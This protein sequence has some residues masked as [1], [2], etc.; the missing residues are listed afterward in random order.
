MRTPI[1]VV[2][3]LFSY[4][5]DTGTKYVLVPSHLIAILYKDSGSTG[6]FRVPSTKSRIRCEYRDRMR[7][8]D[9]SR[10]STM[11]PKIVPF[12]GTKYHFDT[13]P[14]EILITT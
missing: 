4:R 9:I 3:P 12:L 6:T 7:I 2:S 10:S 13:T 1:P 5:R 14:I 11:L 8:S